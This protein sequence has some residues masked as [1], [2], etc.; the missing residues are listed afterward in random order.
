MARDGDMSKDALL[1][2][3]NC[4][5]E[6]AWLDYKE[7]LT[8]EEDR[9]LCDFARDILALKNVGGGFIVVGVHLPP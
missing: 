3:L 9:Q 4:R 8:L 6:C 1:Y 5:A 2:F 7:N